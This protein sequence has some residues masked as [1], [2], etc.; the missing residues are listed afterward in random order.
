[1]KPPMGSNSVHCDIDVKMKVSIELGTVKETS[2]T[3]LKS[4]LEKKFK[5]D[6]EQLVEKLQKNKADPL[7]IEFSYWQKNKDYDHTDKWS[8]EIF[9]SSVV[10]TNMEIDISGGGVTD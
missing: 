10:K 5:S 3:K 9:P 7:R 2:L 6:I 1:M 8:T 4:S